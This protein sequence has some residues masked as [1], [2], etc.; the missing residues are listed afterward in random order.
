[1]SSGRSNRQNRNSCRGW[2][3]RSER[4]S[5]YCPDWSSPFLILSCWYSCVENML[6]GLIDSSWATFFFSSF[7]NGLLTGM[8][9]YDLPIVSF[10]YGI[11]FSIYYLCSGTVYGVT[12]TISI[13]LPI[14]SI[15]L[16]VQ[17]LA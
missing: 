15:Q 10:D 16:L 3:K 5:C 2:P 4:K 1:M 7:I 6:R 8:V 14:L 12:S 17:F 9:P 11:S 13:L